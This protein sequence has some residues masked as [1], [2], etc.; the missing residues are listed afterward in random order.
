MVG[1]LIFPNVT[2]LALQPTATKLL[3]GSSFLK[4]VY[5]RSLIRTLN[6]A[7]ANTFDNSVKSWQIFGIV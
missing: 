7:L 4:P 1:R 6:I 2:A 3:P 5:F